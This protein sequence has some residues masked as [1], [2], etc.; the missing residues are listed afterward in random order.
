MSSDQHMRTRG[1]FT[2]KTNRTIL[3]GMLLIK[4]NEIRNRVTKIVPNENKQS[5]RQK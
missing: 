1:A 2:Y 5:R 4:S 3:N